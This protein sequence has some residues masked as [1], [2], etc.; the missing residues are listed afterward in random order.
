MPSITLAGRR[1]VALSIISAIALGGCVSRSEFDAVQAQNQQLRQEVGRLQGAIR[2]TVNSDLLFASGGWQ[3]SA[4]G[5]DTIA[6]IASQLVSG[7]RN[8][9][10][11]NGYT[12]N[13]PIGASLR[14]Q[15]ITSNEQLSQKR[16]DEVMSFLISQG[17]KPDMVTAVGHG[18]ENPVAPNDTAQGRARNRRVEIALADEVNLDPVGQIN[19]TGGAVAAGIGFSWGSGTLNFR[20]KTYNVRVEGF[21][22]GDVGVART[23]ATG[24]VYN[25]TDISQFSGTYVAVD[26]GVAIAAGGSLITMR[27]PHGVVIQIRS[28]QSGLRL[29]LG[30]QG[31][32]MTI[33]Q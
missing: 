22:V 3:M 12:D 5:K 25:L 6:K 15:G 23:D 21:N 4:E 1:A 7:Q 2:Y 20:G 30:G 16:A 31:V 17:V 28:T 8:R 13:A 11:V 32:T 26:V 14:R 29:T 33:R 27:N 18:A 10:V 19:F 9:L 24:G